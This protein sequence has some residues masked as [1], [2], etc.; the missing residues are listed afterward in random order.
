VPCNEV[1]SPTDDETAWA[2]KIVKALEELENA[3]K[4]VITVEC[5]MVEGLHLVMAKLV[6]AIAVAINARSKVDEPWF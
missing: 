5:K 3:R 4:G 2:R 6:A 1:F